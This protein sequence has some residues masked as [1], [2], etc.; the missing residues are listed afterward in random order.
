MMSPMRIRFIH[1]SMR[2]FK[3]KHHL[4]KLPQRLSSFRMP[5]RVICKRPR[6]TNSPFLT[7]H[8]QITSEIFTDATLST[9]FR[10]LVTVLAACIPTNNSI[11]LDHKV[12]HACIVSTV[13][14]Q[15]PILFVHLLRQ[16]EARHC[17][18]IT[19][20]NFKCT[21][22]CKTSEAPRPH[23]RA[24]CQIHPTFSER[25]IPVRHPNLV[26][27]R[28]SRFR[29]LALF[30]RRRPHATG[31]AHR[32]R[33]WLQWWPTTLL[34]NYQVRTCT[35][36]A[37]LILLFMVSLVFSVDCGV[38]LRSFLESSSPRCRAYRV[39]HRLRWWPMTLLRNFQV[40][41]CTC[42]AHLLV[43]STVIFDASWSTVESFY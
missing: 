5:L 3:A 8:S 35:C 4:G 41:M 20:D 37:H 14:L 10:A 40:R 7:R 6:R 22:I 24:L 43:F 36:V 11:N 19:R 34:R 17:V 39:V 28:P 30:R 25:E 42:A 1:Q 16:L 23:Q 33:F 26:A 18:R 31:V 38:C 29:M 2:H 32:P 12:P 15:Q 13:L 27:V 21:P 9:N